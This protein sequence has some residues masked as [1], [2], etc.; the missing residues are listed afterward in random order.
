MSATKPPLWRNPYRGPMGPEDSAFEDEWDQRMHAARKESASE[1]ARLRAEF[2]AARQAREESKRQQGLDEDKAR[3]RAYMREYM[4][5]YR[6][7]RKG[8]EVR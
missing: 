7:R 5:G 8:E 2:S 1:H 4:R 3:Q 6:A